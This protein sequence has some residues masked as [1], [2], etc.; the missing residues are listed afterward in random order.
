LG[1]AR[2]AQQSDMASRALAADAAAALLAAVRAGDADGVAALL[3]R[4]PGAADRCVSCDACAC[5]LAR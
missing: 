4:A 3:A 1:L 2:A 5:A